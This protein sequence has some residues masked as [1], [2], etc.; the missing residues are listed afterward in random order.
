MEKE[1]IKSE[2][3]N[4]KKFKKMM[5]SLGII[6]ALLLFACL[7]VYNIL[8]GLE[9]YELHKPY[10]EAALPAFYDEYA[11][12][13]IGYALK[14]FFDSGS[15][16]FSLVLCVGIALIMSLIGIVF[17]NRNS[18]VLLVVTD[19]RVY[20]TAIHEKRIDL[21]LDKISAVG[22]GKNKS[23]TISSASGIIKFNWIKNRSEI[24]D[25]VNRLLL[26]RQNK[27]N[28]DSADELK[29]FKELL[30]SGVLSQEEFD[31][32]KKQLLGL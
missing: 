11:K 26:E 16:L 19:K 1:L 8:W 17:Y 7:T 25:I 31:A 27:S 18:K 4:I 9:W 30:D 13:G 3:C 10:N 6:A 14:A 32:K 20:G 12:T 24:H 22:L 2:L 21:P 23:I 28:A 5:I 29:K 15:F